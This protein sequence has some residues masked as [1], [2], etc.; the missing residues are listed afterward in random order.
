M[1]RSRRK[2]NQLLSVFVRR[3][4]GVLVRHKELETALTGY[5]R[6][7]GVHLSDVGF[8]LFHLGLA[9]GVERD[10]RLVSGIVWHA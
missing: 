10:T 2:L 4:G 1:E 6:R 9:D 8:N 7:D 3:S 5:Y